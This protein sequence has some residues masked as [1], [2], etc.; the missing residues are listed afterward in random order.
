MQA[1]FVQL[2]RA[3][4]ARI[5]SVQSSTAVALSC[6]LGSLIGCRR[7]RH[8]STGTLERDGLDVGAQS[9]GV[10]CQMS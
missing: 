8:G 7:K 2:C 4:G 9:C 5:R 10:E 1:R 6:G 3:I